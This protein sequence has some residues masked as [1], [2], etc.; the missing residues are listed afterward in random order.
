MR[1]WIYY[2]LRFLDIPLPRSGWN[3]EERKMA[4]VCNLADLPSPFQT[5][6]HPS[7][8]ITAVRSNPNSPWTSAALLLSRCPKARPSYR[9]RLTRL[10]CY[11]TRRRL[12]WLSPNGP[13]VSV[14]PRSNLLALSVLFGS[15]VGCTSRIV[16]EIFNWLCGRGTG[17]WRKRLKGGGRSSGG[18]S[19]YAVRI[20]SFSDLKAM[21]VKSEQRWKRY[22]L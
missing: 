22:S 7:H 20:E 12:S 6:Q 14:A 4:H 19:C 2:I 8:Q 15:S 16:N 13:R 1:R 11:P 10:A 3:P 9:L 18:C 21:C 5:L 17:A